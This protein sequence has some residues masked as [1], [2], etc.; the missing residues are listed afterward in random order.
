[1]GYIEQQNVYVP[2]YRNQ[3]NRLVAKRSFEASIQEVSINMENIFE[4][5]DK[6]HI[7]LPGKWVYSAVSAVAANIRKGAKELA[8]LEISLR[9]SKITKTARST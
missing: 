5:F 1:L 2:L 4:Y 9:I 6:V 3:L 7:L 8:R